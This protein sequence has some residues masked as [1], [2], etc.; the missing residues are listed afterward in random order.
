MRLAGRRTWALGV[1]ATFVAL[2]LTGCHTEYHGYDSGIDGTLWRQ[3][4]SFEDPLSSSLFEPSAY[5]PIG[6]LNSL[7][8]ERWSG[9]LESASDLDLE[10]GGVV[11]YDRT[12]TDNAAGLSI[13]IASGPRPDVPTDWGRNYD[14][15][16]QVFT[17]YR[18]EAEF[19]P[20]AMPS[21][22]RTTFDHCPPAL[23]ELM[24]ADAAF[25]SGEVFDG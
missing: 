3:I 15:P 18:I 22:G 19:S 13:F 17:C 14:G 1:V 8:A 12:S 10:E 24:P 9:S 6:Y 25:A 20:G 2:S 7:Q 4:A 16:S 5:E 21:V 23:V 11:L